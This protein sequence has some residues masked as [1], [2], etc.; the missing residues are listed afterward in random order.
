MENIVNILI[1]IF[2]LNFDFKLDENILSFT[3]EELDIITHKF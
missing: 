2:H 1:I 3:H